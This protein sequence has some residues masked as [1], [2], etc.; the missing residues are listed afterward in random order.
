MSKNLIEVAEPKDRPIEAV[1]QLRDIAE[2]LR[3]D[4][5]L[6][7]AANLDDEADR[8]VRRYGV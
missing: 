4:S 3:R 6:D 5:H 1:A 2:W 7:L 8:I